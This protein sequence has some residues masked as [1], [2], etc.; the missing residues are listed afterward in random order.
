MPA[1][2]FSPQFADAVES[3]EKTQTIRRHRKK[4]IVAGDTLYLYTGQRT[5]NCRK[6]GEVVC[7]SVQ[8]IAIGEVVI[9]VD[10]LPLDYDRRSLL[11]ERDGFDLDMSFRAWFRDHY[12]LPFHGQLIVWDKPEQAKLNTYR[13]GQ[14]GKIVKRE[15]TKKWI[16]S[17][18]DA[19]GKNARLMLRRDKG[20]NNG[21]D[22]PRK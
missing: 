11:I 19:T 12:G 3:G 22:T 2:N 14:C 17:Y 7:R 21:L 4:P 10:G 20:R 8:D 15:S 18:C 13:C 1:L 16:K 9:S 5:K 6:L